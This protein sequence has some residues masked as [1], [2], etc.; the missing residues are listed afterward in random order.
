MKEAWHLYEAVIGN[1][2]LWFK[3]QASWYSF[4]G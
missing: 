4:S 3:L 1:T 2:R